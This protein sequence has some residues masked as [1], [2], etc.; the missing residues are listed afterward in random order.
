MSAVQSM[1]Q[2]VAGIKDSAMGRS[3]AQS[4]EE[5]PSGFQGGGTA[6]DPYDQGNVERP[7]ESGEEPPSGIQGKGTATDPYDAGNAPETAE[8][9]MVSGQEPPTGIQGKGTATDPYDAGN[10]PENPSTSDTSTAAPS[11]QPSEPSVEST[12]VS[13][14]SAPSSKTATDESADTRGRGLLK[15]PPKHRDET[16]V[17][18]GTMPDGSHAQTSGDRGESYEPGRL[19]RLKGKFGFG[20]H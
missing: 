11:A 10:A 4:G 1:Y 16:D 13:S 12:A 14:T 2:S 5:P 8:A 9:P 18:P 20:H 19:N 15:A 3:S 6:T 7:A 17:S